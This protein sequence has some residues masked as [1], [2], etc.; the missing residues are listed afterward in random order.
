MHNFTSETLELSL[1]GCHRDLAPRNI[2]IHGDT[3]LLADFGLST[4]RNTEEDSLTTYKDVVGSYNAPE[5][6]AL[7]DG[8]FKP[9]KVGRASDIWSF[10]CI[11]AEVLSYTMLGPDG[12]A[13]F[14]RKRQV[15]VTPDTTWCR[16]HRGPENPNPEVAL[17]LDYLIQTN[18]APYQVR[19]VGL[20]RNMLSMDPNKRP[21][22]AQVLTLLRGI[23]I[24][25]IAGSVN[26]GSTYQ[27]VGCIL[28]NMRF[29]SWLV[30]FN[31][32][33]DESDQTRPDSFD[34]D[35]PKI[36]QA[37][38]GM[39]HVFESSNNGGSNAGHRQQSVLRYHHARLTE[40]LPP[41]YRSI[42]R[43]HLVNQILQNDVEQLGSLSKAIIEVGDEAGD[44]DIGVLVAVKHLT[45]LAEMGRLT[46]QSNL[47]L[48]QKSI[49]IGE[50]VDIHTLASLGPKSERVLVEWLKYDE[51]WTD[52]QIGTELRGRLTSVVGLLHAES[53][54][55]IPGS[56]YCK[57]FFHD[58][59]FGAFGV[60]HGLPPS[61]TQPITL[62]G[63]L[64]KGKSY[65]PLLEDRF[66]LAS[67]ICKCIYTFH[68]VGWLH[69]NLHSMNVVFFRRDGAG[70]AE[71][72]KEPRILGF[73]RS[74]EN[75]RDSFT[76]GPDRDHQ[77]RHY[78]HPEYL[79]H[80]HDVRYR[81]EFDYYSVGMLLLEIGFWKTL[82]TITNSDRLKGISDEQFRRE[83]IETRVPHL[84]VAMGTHYMEATR[85]C[86]EGGIAGRTDHPGGGAD[87]CYMSFK[88]LVMDQTRL[89]E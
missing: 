86:L 56:L 71:W 18:E 79:T 47:L 7:Q 72:A 43:D 88:R 23:S 36:A 38:K 26:L 16:F 64:R 60:V 50:D 2:L 44:D 82:S 37:L 48:D 80:T 19:M 3:F 49:S 35:F 10:G 73:A 46:E 66:R 84:G 77:L 45:S 24:L 75:H 85:M 58:E 42:A 29:R 11:L 15:Q 57:G 54:T 61:G 89:I 34:F 1:S 30:A 9:Q 39:R 17:W 40:A 25:S 74:R 28:G 51:S 12:V 32:L 68:K 52:E 41:Y 87:I 33:L 70:N 69:R 6:L 4:F 81:E 27:D 8:R 13:E 59:S 55:Q 67:D 83:V 14:R 62:H 31:R 76:H 20:I 22:S 53:T 78:Q 63:L 65:C 5:C 21:R